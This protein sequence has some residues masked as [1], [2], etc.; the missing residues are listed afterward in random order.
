MQAKKA[1]AIREEW[2]DKPCEHP[3]LAKE[4]SAG[5]RT[6]DYVCTQCGAKVT[7]RERADILASRK[8]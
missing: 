7:F 6:G 5:A 4:Y 8:T 3:K 2:G 1:A